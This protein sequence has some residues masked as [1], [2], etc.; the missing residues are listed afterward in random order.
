MYP[1]YCLITNEDEKIQ[2][3]QNTDVCS[4]PLLPSLHPGGRHAQ[5]PRLNK[6]NQR[7]LQEYTPPKWKESYRYIHKKVKNKI[8]YKEIKTTELFK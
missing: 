2:D 6:I 5:I 3:K 1:D 4:M 8:K 7:F